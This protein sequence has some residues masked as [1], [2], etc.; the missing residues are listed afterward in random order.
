MLDAARCVFTAIEG[1]DHVQQVGVAG[2]GG[3]EHDG[4]IIIS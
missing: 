1:V 2:V 3:S 4:M